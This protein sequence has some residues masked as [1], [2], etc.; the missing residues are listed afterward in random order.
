[1]LK[2]SRFVLVIILCLFVHRLGAA[3]ALVT[4]LQ[5][6]KPQVVVA[7]GTSLTARTDSGKWVADL[8]T[9]LNS[10]YP[11]LA[12][13]INSGQSG[14]ASNTAVSLLSSAVISKN[15]DVVF[16]E[17][18]MNDAFTNFSTTN[19]PVDFSPTIT[20]ARARSNLVSMITSI[21]A[22][23][24]AAE[25]I[26]MTMDVAYDVPVTNPTAATYRL[27]LAAYYQVYRDT[28]ASE[29]L[30]CIDHYPNWKAIYDNN[31]PLYKTYVADGVHPSATASTTVITPTIQSA[32]LA[33]RQISTDVCIYGGTSGGVIAAIQ[34]KKM[35]KTVS[36]VVFNSHLGGMTSGGLGQTDLG[37]ADSI[38]GVA[39]DFYLR[40]AKKYNSAA[41]APQ[42]TFEPKVAE[43]VF[44]E[45]L[46]ENG[47][48]VYYNERLASVQ[49]NGKKITGMTM[50]GGNSYTARM[51]LDCTYEGDLLA[52]AGVN[53]TVGREPNSQYQEANSGIQEG[54]TG[55]QLPNGIDPYVVAGNPASGLLPGVNA[56]S[57]GVNGTGD[58][59]V[60]AYNYR[61][62]LTSNATNRITVAQPAGYNEADYELLFRAIEAGQTTGFWKTDAMPN[63]KTDSNNASGISTDL[64]GGGSSEWAEA[65]Y[66]RRAE[67]AK[68]HEKWQR[69]L[70]WTIQNH[71]RVPLAIRN[72]WAQWGLPADEFL[73]TN[74]WPHQLYVREARRMVSDYVMTEKN[75]LGQ[76]VA[77][78]S[79]ALAS[80]TM[81]SHNTQRYVANG[82]VKNEGDVQVAVALPYPISYR[83][84]VPR[85]GECEN[86]FVT[87]ALSAS[88]MGFGSCRMEPVFMMLGQ[89]AGTAAA[90]AIND[91]VPVQSVNYTKLKAQLVADGQLLTLGT[92]TSDTSIIMDNSD[93]TGVTI[94]GAWTAGAVTNGGQY[95]ADYL[96]DGNALKGTK[97]VRYTP[98]LTAAGT[99]TVYTRWV[100][101]ANRSAAV[102][103]DIVSASG[104]STVT[105]DQRTGGGVWVSLGDYSLVPG[106]ASVLIRTTGTTGFVI[107][108]AV[109]FVPVAALP[110]VSVWTTARS[111]TEPSTAKPSGQAGVVTFAR[112][113]ATAS[114]LTL[115]LAITGTATNGIDY[116]AVPSTVTIPSGKS[117]VTLSITPLTD[118]LV[119]GSESVFVT[120]NTN[121]GYLVDGAL[122]TA[123]LEVSEGTTTA[124][125]EWLLQRGLTPGVLGT[126]FGGD[127]NGDGIPNG[128]EYAL[129]GGLVTA[130]DPGLLTLTAT[131]RVDPTIVMS[132]QSSTTL[133]SWPTTLTFPLDTDQTSVAAGFQRYKFQTSVSA[134]AG[135]LFYRIQMTQ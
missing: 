109:Q 92:V 47:V 113:G 14:K 52:K 100:A 88:H 79:V 2:S 129:P 123:V 96:H 130:M 133:Q 93:A 71:T 75:C 126:G 66:A 112:T 62:C 67:I 30:L 107:A 98:T 50:E 25:I 11:G 111:A 23:N 84:I 33:S 105:V 28:A 87:F 32:L 15:P 122:S 127:A 108:D 118:A 76:V 110:V 63:S 86:L 55:N 34:A 1:M 78:D 8:Q 45:M 54:R 21:R 46:Q 16:I 4:N 65:S 24:P 114:A 73:D 95:G 17:F 6:G 74:N 128:L 119:E 9:W 37:N 135:G 81:D 90:F 102:P 82:M 124:Y 61:M 58:L 60:Q 134:G 40:I 104:T 120:L 91:Q 39:R 68:A 26:L 80:Y 44:R 83:S 99:Y 41:T 36:L 89:S 115:Q 56:T 18:S 19:N 131:V 35:G 59:K 48:P 43:L 103:I 49:M 117:S 97:S 64:I 94:T 69:G 7:Y 20:L 31:L 85:V 3:S 70:I 57:G 125:S 51:F 116:T 72:A 53:Y 10:Q 12:T 121:A 101:N 42:F 5:A 77:S 132:L 29:G 106:A 38:Q 22:S 13:V 27:Q